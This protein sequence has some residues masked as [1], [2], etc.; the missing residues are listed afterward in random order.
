MAFTQVIKTLGSVM[1][2][3]KTAVDTWLSTN[4]TN[5]SNPPLDRSLSLANAC[6]PADMMG[7]LKNKVD[8]IAIY[9]PAGFK[10]ITKDWSTFAGDYDVTPSQES[11]H[12]N[13]YTANNGGWVINSIHTTYYY[14]A[15]DDFK[16]FF[17]SYQNTYVCISLYN[18]A[19]SSSNFIKYTRV[20][21]GVP[22]YAPSAGGE[23]PF[24]VSEETALQVT[25]GQTMAISVHTANS[26]NF[27]LQTNSEAINGNG[28]LVLVDSFIF[29][30]RT[31][32]GDNNTQDK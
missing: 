4:I 19:I 26:S 30:A 25:A 14:K 7:N 15:V 16:V 29:L 20:V 1:A 31:E 24:P 21:N 18:G 5:P 17:S 23:V 22:S 3:M 28:S 10:P 11:G 13:G 32:C 12:R 27:V 6:A 8:N 9:E 2:S